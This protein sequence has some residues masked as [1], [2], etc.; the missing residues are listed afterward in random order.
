MGMYFGATICTGVLVY[1]VDGELNSDFVNKM[2]EEANEHNEDFY[3]AEFLEDIFKDT[4]YELVFGGAEEFQSMIITVPDI[5]IETEWSPIL[6]TDIDL[7]I[8]IDMQESILDIKEKL[9]HK[10]LEY[11][12]SGTFLIP[13]YYN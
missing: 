11:G 10:G 6:I 3:M 8:T 9:K 5:T 7:N 4:K 1:E 2:E 13:Y 12:D